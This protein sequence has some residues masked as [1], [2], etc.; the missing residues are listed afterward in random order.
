ML[1]GLLPRRA[2]IVWYIRLLQTSHNTVGRVSEGRWAGSVEAFAGVG[3][4]VVQGCEEGLFVTFLCAFAS[5]REAVV[6]YF[7]ES[8]LFCETCGCPLCALSQD[9]GVETTKRSSRNA[10]DGGNAH[11]SKVHEQGAKTRTTSFLTKTT[12]QFCQDKHILNTNTH[13][14][15]TNIPDVLSIP[16]LVF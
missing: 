5:W 15:T 7:V 2:F 6:V 10:R 16:S 13:H 3:T 8:Q 9:F 12:C 14:N 11:Q 1:V 4:T